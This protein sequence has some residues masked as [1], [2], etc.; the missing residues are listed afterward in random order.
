ML[1]KSMGYTCFVHHVWVLPGE[2]DNHNV[3]AEDQIEYILNN[4]AF[5][6]GGFKSEVQQVDD[7]V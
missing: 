6:P 5:F 1:A 4:R 7:D 3:S 2:I